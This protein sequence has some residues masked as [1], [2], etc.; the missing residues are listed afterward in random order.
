M[1][2]IYMGVESVVYYIVFMIMEY[3]NKTKWFRAPMKW[4]K[5]RGNDEA[6]PIVVSE[7]VKKYEDTIALKS[8]SFKIEVGETLAII[9]PNG[10]GKSSLL[11]VLSGCCP[12]D[13]G[14]IDFVGLDVTEDIEVMHRVV[15][16]CPQENL[17]MNE[18]N[19]PEWIG[20]LCSLRGIADYDFSE[21]F[22]ALGLNEQTTGRIGSMSGGNK[23]K[24]C[25]A[26]AL[27]GNPSI[28][29]LDEATSGVDFTSRTR[30][31][32]LI[33]GL[34]DT[35]VIMATHTLEECEKIADRIM[36]VSDGSITVVDTPTA[37]RQE[38]K[39]GYLIE[40]E[41]SNAE[42]L[43]V[44]LRQHGLDGSSIEVNE[45]RATTVISA[46]EHGLLGGIL[47]DMN[48]KY[49]MSI[50]NL[51]EKVFSHIQEQELSV[52][53]RRDSTINADDEDHHPRV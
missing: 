50:Q 24:V 33:S 46:E 31:W 6:T 48:F 38:F 21:I 14:S 37:L 23:R 28:V 32:S 52:L 16:Y 35:T 7:L 8:I 41:E 26:S 44:I 34:K 47:K 36:V 19:G 51:E 15:G 18:L 12:C 9:G 3:V 13:G 40:T 49:L 11:G 20:A 10:A 42:Q 30:I 2:F 45:G 1:G 25:L 43:G 39:C 17:F 5:G 27:I 4:G 29:I 22:S 53:H